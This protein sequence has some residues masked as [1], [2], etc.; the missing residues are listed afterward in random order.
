M[1]AGLASQKNYCAVYLMGIAGDGEQA[2]RFEDDFAQ[3]GKKL[4][5]GKGC[6]R[7]RRVDDLALDAIGRVIA[8]TTPEQYI[9][10]YEKSRER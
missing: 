8:G 1:Y 9:A 5:R 4:D 3:A 2:R 10:L 6:V 7:F